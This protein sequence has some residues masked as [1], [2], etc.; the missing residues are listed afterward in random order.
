MTLTMAGLD[1]WPMAGSIPEGVDFRGRLPRW[2][3]IPLMD[4]HDLLVMPSRFEGFGV[5]FIEAMARGLPCIGRNAFAMPELIEPGVTGGLVE[6]LDP[7]SLA[8]MI[9]D[10]LANDAIYA[11]VERRAPQVAQRF[12]WDRTAASVIDFIEKTCQPASDTVPDDQPIT[13]ADR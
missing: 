13:S 1:R 5:V 9:E 7:T 12:T 2:Q 3:V 6:V 11:E 4:E 10:V 8:D